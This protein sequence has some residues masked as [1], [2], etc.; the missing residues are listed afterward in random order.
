MVFGILLILPI[1]DFA[2]AAPVTAR[3]KLHPGVD[4]VH[5]ED[6]T[7]MLW[8]RGELIDKL[9]AEYVGASV[10]EEWSS[11]RP[12]KP[13]DGWTNVKR[14]LTP[15]P[16]E[17]S[18]EPGPLSSAAKT[19]PWVESSSP[20]TTSSME[21]FLDDEWWDEDEHGITYYPSTTSPKSGYEL[22]HSLTGA[23]LSQPNTNPRPSKDPDFDRN[24]GINLED[25]EELPPPKRPKPATSNE[26]GQA[27]YYEMADVQPN[28]GLS[29]EPVGTLPST[30]LG[31]PKELDGGEAQP[32]D[33][34]DALYAAKG[35]AKV[36]RRVPG[37]S[38]D[39]VDAVQR[40]LRFVKRTLDPGE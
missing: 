20:S 29:T 6:A 28:P 30:D 26:F 27:Q 39:V 22:D 37:T 24:D 21:T 2:V 8:K 4:V 23:D 35:K 40:E 38:R 19:E 15:I 36:L 32:V 13:A 33:P 9:W 34:Q 31:S 16:E 14:P 12:L 1:V 10:P 3:E 5:P 17:P 25:L 11:L 7:T 18:P